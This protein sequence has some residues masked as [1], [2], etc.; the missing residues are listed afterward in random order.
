MLYGT[1]EVSNVIEDKYEQL[2]NPTFSFSNSPQQ[3]R[4]PGRIPQ[5]GGKPP[6][7]P[8][9]TNPVDGIEKSLEPQKAPDSLIEGGG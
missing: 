5:L 4:N 3:P 7:R 2:K 1:P 8:P 6:L 9:S